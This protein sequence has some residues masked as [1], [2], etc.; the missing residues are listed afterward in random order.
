[1][2]LTFLILSLLTFSR[3]SYG[4]K[5]LEDSSL[6]LSDFTFN[7]IFG[8]NTKDKEN[9]YCLLATG[10]IR[11]P[12]SENLDSLIETWITKHR[13]ANIIPVYSMEPIDDDNPTLK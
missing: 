7:S 6:K 1:M 5:N 2:K 4:Q 12:R 13:S 3:I 8:R 9:L 10:W 11:A